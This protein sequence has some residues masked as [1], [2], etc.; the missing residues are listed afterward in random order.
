MSFTILPTDSYVSPGYDPGLAKIDNYQIYSLIIDDCNY[1]TALIEY[2]N[3]FGY[4]AV[5]GYL[6]PD[7]YFGS[8]PYTLNVAAY[9]ITTN[10]PGVAPYT[11]PVVPRRLYDSGSVIDVYVGSRIDESSRVTAFQTFSPLG[12]ITF[13]FAEIAKAF[14]V[15]GT[16]KRIWYSSAKKIQGWAEDPRPNYQN[17]YSGFMTDGR[18]RPSLIK[19]IATSTRVI[20]WGYYRRNPDES[21]P[22]VSASLDWH[23]GM[24][25]AEKNQP[26]TLP[27]LDPVLGTLVVDSTTKNEVLASPD[28][29]NN[30][31]H[32]YLFSDAIAGLMAYWESL[33]VNIIP[34]SLPS[35]PHIFANSFYSCTVYHLDGDQVTFS[36]RTVAGPAAKYSVRL[37]SLPTNDP[38]AY[39]IL[40]PNVVSADL[41][42]TPG[43]PITRIVAANNNRWKYGSVTVSD[44]P[45]AANHPVFSVNEYQLFEAL[46]TDDSFGSLTMDSPRILEIH[47]ALDAGQYA[48]DP[49]TGG[50]RVANLGHLIKRIGEVLGYRPKPDGTSDQAAEKTTYQRAVLKAGAT[51][52][53]GDYLAGRFGKRGLLM[54]RLPNKKT[55][56]GW[57]AGGYVAIHDIPQLLTEVLDQL[58]EA[59]N[60]QDST[61]I[62]VKDGDKTYTYASQLALL[63]EMATTLIPQK[64]QL[65]E[66]WTSSLVSQQSINEVI[67]GIGLPTVAKSVT[68]GGA[69]LPY[70]GIQPDKSLQREIATVAYNV[71]LGNGQIL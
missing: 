49:V 5:P 26:Y 50:A 20:K 47:A 61:S 29:P 13:D 68:I 40:P 34:P 69:R 23:Q 25:K 67:A 21:H 22:T 52:P 35:V 18:I 11:D 59:M 36:L 57:E 12:K 2:Y 66:I 15:Q 30:Y 64:R 37:Y 43:T 9:P 41:M 16:A 24:I 51:P 45:P 60:L 54:R 70:W 28:Q 1:N 65:K 4:G 71:G 44:N 8:V 62:Q 31:P 63:V 39:I 32:A 46:Q 56:A 10:L 27:I 17:L 48:I 7:Q 3:G 42:V 14:P 19:C 55:T 6:S 53:A 38:N 58:N 33:R